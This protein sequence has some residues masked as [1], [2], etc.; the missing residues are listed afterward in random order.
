MSK[1]MSETI[2]NL[3][4][5]ISAYSVKLL[6]LS[7]FRLCRIT[8]DFLFT[9]SCTGKRQSLARLASFRDSPLCIHNLSID[10]L[11]THG[12]IF[13]N[14][15][16]S[17]VGTKLLANYFRCR[18]QFLRRRGLRLRRHGLRVPRP[19]SLRSSPA[20]CDGRRRNAHAGQ[21]VW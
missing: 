2:K 3:R 21:G 6:A 7:T 19:P 12:A 5:S 20:A 9:A 4:R 11:R 18:F 14:P 1:E 8:F 16:C 10:H 15:D 13:V 17:L